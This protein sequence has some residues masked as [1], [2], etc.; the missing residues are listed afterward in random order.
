MTGCYGFLKLKSSIS[1]RSDYWKRTQKT[2]RSQVPLKTSS[3]PWRDPQKSPLPSLL[4][5]LGRNLFSTTFPAR[6]GQHR[7]WKYRD[8]FNSVSDSSEVRQ[9]KLH[10]RPSTLRTKAQVQLEV[11]LPVYF[12]SDSITVFT[13]PCDSE[14]R[15]FTPSRPT[16]KNNQSLL[17]RVPCAD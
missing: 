12:T 14:I 6:Q 1:I 7:D 10:H 2:R 5:T 11:G 15:I 17:A 8:E 3:L 13:F 16:N 9:I 4:T